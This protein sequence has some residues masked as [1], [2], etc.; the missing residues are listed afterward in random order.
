MGPSLSLVQ[1]L[2]RL[3][4]IVL[5]EL[6]REKVLSRL[7]SRWWVRLSVPLSCGLLAEV[8]V[9]IILPHLWRL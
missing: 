9:Y 4:F 1:T 2:V 3:L 7:R 5:S 8:M 6:S